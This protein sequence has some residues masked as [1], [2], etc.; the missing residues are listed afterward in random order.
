MPQRTS[1]IDLS[2]RRMLQN[3]ASPQGP[4]PPP[5]NAAGSAE[6]NRIAGVRLIQNTINQ[7]N[8]ARVNGVGG[9]VDL[10]G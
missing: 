6:A 1:N 3:I 5:R 9:R 2:P 8:T 7:V 4:L 10:L